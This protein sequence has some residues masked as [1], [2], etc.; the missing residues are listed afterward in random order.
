MPTLKYYLSFWYIKIF[1]YLFLF[2]LLI[3]AISLTPIKYSHLTLNELLNRIIAYLIN[4][5]LLFI[6]LIT[7]EYF[8]GNN[9]F[10]IYGLSNFHKFLK[11]FVHTFFVI[12]LLFSSIVFANYLLDNCASNLDKFLIETTLLVNL[13]IIFI[14]AL[15]EELIFRGFLINSLELRFSATSSIV[16]SSIIFALLHILNA[17]FSM[18]AA[19][20][21]FLAGLLLGLLYVQSRSIWLPV[22]YHFFWNAMIP[23]L[24]N[25]NVSGINFDYS[26]FVINQSKFQP[27][28]NGGDYGFE[29]TISATLIVILSIFYFIKIETLNPYNSSYKFMKKFELESYLLKNETKNIEQI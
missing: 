8:S 26:I 23:L 9:I 27:I 20:N 22:L 16:L 6:P 2:I 18:L 1:A 7:V 17:N 4:F 12:S 11:Y 5:L 21:T 19:L 14:A 24:L 3:I 29:G 10:K 28:L 13:T 25:S 15:Q